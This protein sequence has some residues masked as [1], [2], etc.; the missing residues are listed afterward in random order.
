MSLVTSK[1]QHSGAIGSSLIVVPA[2]GAVASLLFGLAYAYITVYSPIGGWISILFV[3]G[4]AFAVGTTTV[5]AI[6]KSKCRNTA[7]ASLLAALVSLFALYSAWVFFLFALLRRSNAPLEWADLPTLF[8]SPLVNWNVIQVI[9]QNGWF[10]M[11]GGPVAGALL[12]VLWLIEAAIIVGMITML[13]RNAI[14]DEVFCER[15]RRWAASGET[16]LLSVPEKLEELQGLAA[17]HLDGLYGLEPVPF[18]EYPRMQIETKR[19]GACQDLVTC[20][21]KA[22]SQEIDKQGSA[23]EKAKDLTGNLIISRDEYN[24]LEALAQRPVPIDEIDE[25][26]EEGDEDSEGE[27]Q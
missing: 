1:Y 6:N 27:L 14:S 20:K 16:L 9:G 12:W 24:R 2:V 3:L 8:A 4:F 19:C 10:V 21:I 13:G 5:M 25:I 18:D 23:V 7:V 26:D 22:M 11:F 17:G 15:C